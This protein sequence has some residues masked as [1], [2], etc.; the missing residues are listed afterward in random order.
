MALAEMAF[1]V[2]RPQLLPLWPN[3]RVLVGL[4]W[5]RLSDA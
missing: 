3:A 2:E 5:D 4:T 1:G